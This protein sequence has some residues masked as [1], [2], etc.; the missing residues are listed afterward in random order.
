MSKFYVG[1]GYK[2]MPF[3]FEYILENDLDEMPL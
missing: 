3:S 2:F 1:E